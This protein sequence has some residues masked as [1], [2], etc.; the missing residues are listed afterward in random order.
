MLAP[1]TK[2][3]SHKSQSAPLIQFRPA[4]LDERVRAFEAHRNQ[5]EFV[6][7]IVDTILTEYITCG[8]ISVN[9]DG[10]LVP[11]SAALGLRWRSKL[12]R[13]IYLCEQVKELLHGFFQTFVTATFQDLTRL[14]GDRLNRTVS[15]IDVLQ[16]LSL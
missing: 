4:K 2:S 10:H 15:V 9:T 6:Y 14:C 16:R 13:D 11:T 3:K 12:P 1:A 8:I 7:Q 5:I